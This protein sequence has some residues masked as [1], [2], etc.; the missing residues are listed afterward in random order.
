MNH[1]PPY[2]INARYAFTDVYSTQRETELKRNTFSGPKLN[3]ELL[4]CG[5]K[6][7]EKKL[8]SNFFKLFKRRHGKATFFRTLTTDT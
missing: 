6:P 2:F 4:V 8:G 1:R 3:F 7:A 5:E